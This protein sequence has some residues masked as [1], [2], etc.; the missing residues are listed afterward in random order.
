MAISCQTVCSQERFGLALL[1]ECLI[2]LYVSRLI[3]IDFFA[4][5]EV[6]FG[7]LVLR[8][9]LGGTWVICVLF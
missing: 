5:I 6:D 4:L 3:Q 7:G 9:V 1:L 8:N 2:W